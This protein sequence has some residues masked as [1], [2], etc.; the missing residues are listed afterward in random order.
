[1]FGLRRRQPELGTFVL[2][3]YNPDCL[4]SISTV[5]T[6]NLTINGKYRYISYPFRL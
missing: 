5:E 3:T 2:D 6:F 1:M 4:I